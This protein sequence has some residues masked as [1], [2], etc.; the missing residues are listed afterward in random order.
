MSVFHA[1]LGKFRVIAS[2]LF[3]RLLSFL[4]LLF[5][6]VFS[7]LCHKAFDSFEHLLTAKPNLANQT[8]QTKLTK[9]TKFAQLGLTDKNK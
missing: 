2:V 1:F 3:F 7:T 5:L 6:R 4:S 8:K 9:P